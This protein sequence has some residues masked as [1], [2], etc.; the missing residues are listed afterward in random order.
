LDEDDRCRGIGAKGRNSKP[1]INAKAKPAKKSTSFAKTEGKDRGR[2]DKSTLSLSN[3]VTPQNRPA[4]AAKSF[5]LSQQRPGHA[6]GSTAT[7]TEKEKATYSSSS[8]RHTLSGDKENQPGDLSG[9]FSGARVGISDGEEDSVAQSIEDSHTKIKPTKELLQMA[10]KFADV[11]EWE[12]EFEDV[13]LTGN[14]SPN[15]R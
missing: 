11:D 14:S 3:L 12:M 2:R 8:R 10:K 15:R 1:A 7:P 9:D 6:H 5:L 4:A 13:S